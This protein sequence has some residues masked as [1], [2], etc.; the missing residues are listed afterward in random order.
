[1]HCSFG[2]NCC[3]FGNLSHHLG[4]YLLVGLTINAG[5]EHV[6]VTNTLK[7]GNKSCSVATLLQ[8]FHVLAQKVKDAQHEKNTLQE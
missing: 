7:G 1:V 5:I 2:G 3:L 6:Y 4:M 8:M